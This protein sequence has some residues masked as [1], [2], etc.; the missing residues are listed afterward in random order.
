MAGKMRW[1]AVA[2][3]MLVIFILSTEHFSPEKTATFL[4]GLFGFSIRKVAHW[5]E[6]FLLGVL[7]MRALRAKADGL[8]AR[9]HVV[10]SLAIAV[11]Y[12]VSDEWHQSFVASRNAQGIDVGLDALGAVC[13]TW[14]WRYLGKYFA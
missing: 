9:R 3:W 7:L 4:P 1:F 8:I 2:L 10:L 13:G 14:S 5:T 12:A 6:Y 11:A